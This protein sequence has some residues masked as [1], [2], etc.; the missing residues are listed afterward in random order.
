MQ[1]L[2][3]NQIPFLAFNTAVYDAFD[4]KSIPADPFCNSWIVTNVGD[5]WVTVNGILLKGFPIGQPGLVGASIGVTGNYGE[6]YRGN[7]N[8]QSAQTTAGSGTTQFHCI[9]IQKCY[10]VT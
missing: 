7:I 8:I 9:V 1:F 5:I 2:T 6:I 3:M 4:S 10:A